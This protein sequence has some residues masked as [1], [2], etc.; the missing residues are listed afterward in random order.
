MSTI[1]SHSPLNISEETVR[2]RDLIPNSKRPPTGNGLR[3]IN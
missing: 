3:G 1:M 2:D